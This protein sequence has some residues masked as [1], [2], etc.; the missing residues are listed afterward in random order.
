MRKKNN[1]WALIA[2]LSRDGR[3]FSPDDSNINDSL[4]RWKR[5]SPLRILFLSYFSWP[6]LSS[7]LLHVWIKEY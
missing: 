4:A 2:F 7:P 5:F 1:W 3:P 6:F